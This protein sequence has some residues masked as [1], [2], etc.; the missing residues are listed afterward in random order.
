MKNLLLKLMA[1]LICFSLLSAFVACN[2][3]PEGTEQDGSGSGNGGNEAPGNGD[4][5]TPGDDEVPGESGDEETPG[6]SGGETAEEVVSEEKWNAMV[7]AANFENYSFVFSGITS[8]YMDGRLVV[9]NE[10]VRSTYHVTENAVEMIVDDESIIIYDEDAAQQ[11]DELSCLFL[12]ILSEYDN[13]VYDAEKCV[14]TID[15]AVI[16]VEVTVIVDGTP[17]PEKT[18]MRVEV[19]NGEATVSRDGKVV[20][21]VC[22]YTQSLTQMG[23]EI[24][25]TGATE[26]VFYDYGTTVISKQ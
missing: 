10:D 5:E 8:T 9:E 3:G 21:L 19:K 24:T 12:A 23:Y 22:D 20:K 1:V 6:E 14:Y 25:I 16:E 26:W 13:F 17:A 7:S 11:K 2:K 18:P 15:D 4:D